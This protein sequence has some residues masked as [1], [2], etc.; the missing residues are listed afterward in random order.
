MRAEAQ[1]QVASLVADQQRREG[2]SR[3]LQARA[4]AH[5]LH[6]PQV[7]CMFSQQ[8]QAKQ[9]DSNSQTCLP[10]RAT[11]RSSWVLEDRGRSS[12]AR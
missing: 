9:L 12:K 11:F 7:A 6:L 8:G 3:Q 2:A 1:R 10:P 5:P 4:L